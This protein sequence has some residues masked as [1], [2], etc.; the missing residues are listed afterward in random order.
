MKP[1]EQKAIIDSLLQ[2]DV[3]EDFS[4]ILYQAALDHKFAIGQLDTYESGR[5]SVTKLLNTMPSQDL[6]ALRTSL[7]ETKSQIQQ[8]QDSLAEAKE[9]YSDQPVKVFQTPL[10][11]YTN[12]LHQL[13]AN[14]TPEPSTNQE[15]L[16][17]SR[18]TLKDTLAILKSKRYK[19]PTAVPNTTGQQLLQLQQWLVVNH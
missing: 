10:Y 4:K 17:E 13:Q 18:Q 19:Q 16:K 14:Q 1:Q 6:D 7:S 8:L 15:Q 12:D 3:V 5:S 2:L 9:N 11:D